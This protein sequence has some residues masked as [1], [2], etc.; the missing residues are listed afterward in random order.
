MKQTL[1]VLLVAWV[2]FG[3]SKNKEETPVGGIAGSVSDKMT[4]EPVA[5]VIVSL[6]PGGLSRVTGSDGTF[7]FTNLNEGMYT[8]AIHK[9]GYLSSES[10]FDV[11]LGKLTPAHL[12]IERIPAVVTTDLNVL[13]FGSDASV[14]TLSFK[15]VNSSYE[16]LAWEIEHSCPWIQAVTPPNGTLGFGKTGTISV[17]I[18]RELLDIGDNKTV[19]VVKSSNGSSQVEVKAIG[20]ERMLPVLNTLEVTDITRS[21]VTLNGKILNAGTPAY[22]E[23]GFVYN[24]KPK[25]T[26]ENTLKQLTAPVTGKDAYS[27]HLD[28]LTL[29]NTYYARAYAKNNKGVAYATN[30]VVFQPST[31]V[32]VVTIQ[33]VSDLDLSRGTVTLNGTVASAGDPTYIEKGFVYN[34]QPTPTINDNKVEVEGNKT[35][36]YRT[37]VT[38][39]P[40]DK[41]FYARAYITQEGNTYYSSETISFIL[42]T[43]HPQSEMLSI[44]ETGY[45]TRRAKFT[46]RIINE[47]KPPYSRRGFVYGFNSNP[48]LE[49]D[50]SVT[51]TGNGT[52][53]FSVHVP[54]LTVGQKYF[55]RVFT[56]QNG[57]TFY[58]NKELNF[59]LNPIAASISAATASEIRV[60]SANLTASITEVGDPGYT[61]K[62][63]VF[64]T[65]G[66]PQTDNNI[67]KIIADG[68]GEG[69]FSSRVS[70]LTGNTLYYVRAYVKQNGNTYY[71]SETSFKTAKQDAS[72]STNTASNVM[73]T[74][75]TLNATVTATGNPAYNCRGFYYGTNPYLTAANGT[76]IAEEGNSFGDYSMAVTGLEESTTYYFRSFLLQPGDTQPTLGDIKSFTTGRAPNITTGGVTNISCSGSDESSFIWSATFSGGFSD[77]GNPA[78]TEVGF[79]YGT[80]NLPT[81]NDGSS[82]YQK[83]TSL[84]E[85]KDILVFGITLGGLATGMHYYIRAVGKT[86]LGY[87]YGGPVEFTPSVIIP[88]VRTYSAKCY[89]FSD[90]WTV[91]FEGLADSNGQPSIVGFGFVYGLDPSPKVEDGSSIAIAAEDINKKNN[92]YGFWT[93]LKKL[94]EGKNYYVR[95]Y[96]RTQL[97]YFYGDVLNFKTY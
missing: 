29:G 73:Y 84:R 4:G 26:L 15:I 44:T 20:A 34:D 6:S 51:V 2:L 77:E 90:G 1:Y 37:H 59:S 39:L 76:R 60:A 27:C 23:R 96:I 88:L 10:K 72:V 47:G 56:E 33:E 52:G 82:V 36:T 83:A 11:Q 49:N 87:V 66:N 12:L 86:P 24:T 17:V 67:G 40:L 41:L 61:E 68:T 25:P 54:E 74:T 89:H 62:G 97:G 95:A 93:E 38:N 5:T 22:T 13:D 91:T 42:S 71:G 50:H 46:G 94:E 35:G 16:N 48:V 19:L 63:F 64:N 65:E 92:L 7:D 55:V 80:N 75:A 9:E 53:E 45:S 3:C 14:N 85:N 57:N 30:E 43:E 79:V 70:N 18:D 81:F 32:P 28:G 31:A 21:S 78:C 58:S 8:L 69:T